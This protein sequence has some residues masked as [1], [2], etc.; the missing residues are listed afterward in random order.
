[1]Y[2][3]QILAVCCI[4]F[5]APYFS[6]EKYSKTNIFIK[7]K[8]KKKIKK[9]TVI[10]NVHSDFSVNFNPAFKYTQKYNNE[11][12]KE[13]ADVVVNEGSGIGRSILNQRRKL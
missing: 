9:N 4:S 5:D 12:P 7:S 11:G 2:N 13:N 1:M 3:N 6:H 8:Q 10:E